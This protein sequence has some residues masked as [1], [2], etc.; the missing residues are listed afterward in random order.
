MEHFYSFFYFSNKKNEVRSKRII[1]NHVK[2]KPAITRVASDVA[3]RLGRFNALHVRRNDFIYQYPQRDMS[4]KQI[5]NSINRFFAL[6]SKLYIATDESNLE[7]FSIFHAHYKVYFLADFKELVPIE[8]MP[9]ELACVEQVI[10]SLSDIFVGTRWS[11][12]SA[13]ITRLRGYRGALD[14]GIHFTDGFS[15][16]EYDRQGSPNYSWFNWMINGH[17]WWGRE[18]KEAWEF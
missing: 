8:M 3:S 6:G 17:P 11:T 16:T 12:Y 9:E 7:F 4:A 10:C 13:Y 2:F 18:Y 5:F 1:R 15:T 14:L